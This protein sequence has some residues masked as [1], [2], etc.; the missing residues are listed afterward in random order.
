MG[1]PKEGSGDK[2]SR[3]SSENV[4]GIGKISDLLKR[5]V[6]LESKVA[7]YTK[8]LT[9]LQPYVDGE[10]VLENPEGTFV[11]M[12]PKENVLEIVRVLSNTRIEY[13]QELQTL[14]GK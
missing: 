9:D 2:K 6:D 7:V 14:L 13:L 8:I 3:K 4:P 12:I 11:K 1:T 5:V 10:E